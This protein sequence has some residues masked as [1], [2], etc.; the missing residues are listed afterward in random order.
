MPRRF[1]MIL[2]I[3]I[4]LTQR[5]RDDRYRLFYHFTRRLTTLQ[6]LLR[7]DSAGQMLDAI[8]AQPARLSAIKHL[9]YHVARP[10]N[11]DSFHMPSTRR[12][13]RFSR[14]LCVAAAAI[15]SRLA[16]PATTPITFSLKRI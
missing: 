12:R 1:S 8:R 7:G 10:L 14:L 13:Y 5:C 11:A 15:S 6:A 9:Q 4:F 3:S 2:D 16:P